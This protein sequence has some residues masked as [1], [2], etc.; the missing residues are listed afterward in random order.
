MTFLLA[1][2]WYLDILCIGYDSPNL[3]VVTHSILNLWRKSRNESCRGLLYINWIK[4]LPLRCL[5]RHLCLATGKL[6]S[7]FRSLT[8][9]LPLFTISVNTAVHHSNMART[10][11]LD[12]W[13][14][15]FMFCKHFNQL[16]GGT[17]LYLRIHRSL[18][19]FLIQ[20]GWHI[21][22]GNDILI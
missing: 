18:I 12:P 2:F 9:M 5:I 8:H 1:S 6:N 11:D 7:C 20:K 21:I 3:F 19:L 15:L 16:A 14:N 13:G 17:Y 10:H 22:R 4:W